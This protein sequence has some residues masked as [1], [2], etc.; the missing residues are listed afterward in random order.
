MLC[1]AI[2]SQQRSGTHFL[3]HLLNT[4]PSVHCFGEVLTPHDYDFTW[5]SFIEQQT[6]RH[7]PPNLAA[8]AD[9]LVNDFFE[10]LIQLVPE[11]KREQLTAVGINLKYNQLRFLHPICARLSSDSVYLADCFVRNDIRVIHLVRKNVIHVGISDQIASARN[12]WHRHGDATIDGQYTI[13]IAWLLQMGREIIQ[14]REYFKRLL[15]QGEMFEVFYEELNHLVNEDQEKLLNAQELNLLQQLA[16]FILV[17]PSFQRPTTI[18]KVI[19]RPYA[20]LIENYG[21]VVDAV[22]DS[23][24]S[25]FALQL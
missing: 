11:Q 7:Y 22:R 15:K 13:N 16:E 6:L 9:V 5:H 3:T 21:D 19:D 20:D 8:D 23:E 17:D 25:E 10:Y 4:H 1:F 12:V 14:D 18:K 2:V 24:F